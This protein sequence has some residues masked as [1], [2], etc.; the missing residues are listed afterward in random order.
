[1]TFALTV[2]HEHVAHRAAEGWDWHQIAEEADRC[3]LMSGAVPV[4]ALRPYS[5]APAWAV[6]R[7]FALAWEA[8]QKR[9]VMA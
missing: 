8:L 2:A 4:S 5:D 9:R 7:A 3:C 1:M 6:E